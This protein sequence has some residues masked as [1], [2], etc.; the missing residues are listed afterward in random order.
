MW[1]LVLGFVTFL[2]TVSLGF[3]LELHS[4]GRLAGKAASA[5]EEFVD[6]EGGILG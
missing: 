6:N 3:C 2:S 1:V 4:R 5:C